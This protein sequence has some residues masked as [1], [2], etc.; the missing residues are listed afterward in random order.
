M[1]RNMDV[2]HGAGFIVVS[3]ELREAV[4]RRCV[5]TSVRRATMDLGT[6]EEVLHRIMDLGQA[7]ASVAEKLSEKLLPSKT[8]DLCTT[9]ARAAAL[10]EVGAVLTS[11]TL[12]RRNFEDAARSCL[13][14]AR[15][16]RGRA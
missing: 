2:A 15:V 6:T 9:L 3:R 12:Q 4:Q 10:L 14:A 13:D 8:D 16:L 11:N 1:R 5:S 7:R